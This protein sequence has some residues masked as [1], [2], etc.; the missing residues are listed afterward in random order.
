[1][2]VPS[3]WPCTR[4]PPSGDPAAVGSSRFTSE[5]GT[6]RE[7]VVRAMVSAARSAEKRGG[8]ASGSMVSAVRQTPQTATLS[9][10]CSRS[11]IVG[12]AIVSRDAPAVGVNAITSPV[13][14][15]SPVNIALA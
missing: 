5:P 1:M 4:C 11:T 9:P 7:S 14:S 8:K 6:S 15:T 13:V 12:A 3:T 10:I 2:P